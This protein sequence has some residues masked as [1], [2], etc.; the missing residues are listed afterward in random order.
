MLTLGEPSERCDLV[1]KV[2]LQPSCCQT[3]AR[4]MEGHAS[5]KSAYATAALLGR[6]GTLT[7]APYSQRLVNNGLQDQSKGLMDIWVQR[8]RMHK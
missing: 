1:F 2:V 7:C 3:L 4:G 5:S 8:R 6:K